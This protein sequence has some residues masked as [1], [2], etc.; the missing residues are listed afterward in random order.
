MSA[1]VEEISEHHCSLLPALAKLA[2]TH[3]LRKSI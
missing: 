1:S 3:K 2:N